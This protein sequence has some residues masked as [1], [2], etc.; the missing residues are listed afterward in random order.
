[1]ATRLAILVGSLALSGA[2]A[3]PPV[4]DV[5]LPSE[6]PGKSAPL[7]ADEEA[8]RDALTRFGVGLLRARHDQIAT[9]AKQQEAAAKKQPTAAAPQKEL[10]KLYAELGREPAAAAAGEKALAADPHDLDTAR[11]LGRLYADARRHADA[12]RVLRLAAASKELTDPVSKLVVLKDLAKAADAANDPVAATARTD[13]LALLKERRVKFLHPD[14]FTVAELERERLRQYE[15]LGVALLRKAEFAAAVAAFESARDIAA[16][17]KGAND[18]AGVVRLHWNLSG[19]RQ[20]QGDPAK[21][22]A[23]LEK[24]LL[25]RPTAFEPYERFV[26]LMKQQKRGDELPRRLSDLADANPKILA[27]QWLAAADAVTRTPTVVHET[28]RKLIEKG[29]TPDE[30]R[31]LTA[32]YRDADKPKELLDL[33]DRAYKAVRPD[34]GEEPTPDA[35]V[36]ADAVARSRLFT[37]AVRRMKPTFTDK[38]ITQASADLT[39]GIVRHTDT[40][41]LLYGLAERDGHMSAVADLLERSAMKRVKDVRV[42]G[43]TIAAHAHLR[44][45]DSIIEKSERL[46]HADAGRFYPHI[47]AQA[48]IAYAEL[49]R[50]PQALKAL[51]QQDLGNTPNIQSMRVRVLN[52]LG[53]HA[54][55]I[56][57]CD[58]GLTNDRLT[59]AEQRTLLVAKATTLNYQKKYAEAEAIWRELLDAAPDD[60]TVLNNLGYELADQN[61]KLD[62]AETLLRR[63]VEIDAWERGRQG[64]PDA[65]NAGYQDS[66]AWAL[67]RRGKLKE[68]RALLETAVSMPDASG[69][70]I[71]WD[72]LGDVAFRQGDKK[73]AAEAWRKAADLYRGSHVGREKGRLDEVKAKVKLAE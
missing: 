65:E 48:A 46:S 38:L 20:A 52:I 73:R 63:A 36:N 10:A 26:Q 39:A 31:V 19:V 17:P 9:A 47:V 45:W 2:V 16:D 7:S 71:V 14:V 25:H 13:A 40:L 18:P 56:K 53:D 50:K 54:A 29:T 21:A 28:F 57:E 5:P 12:V 70:G 33:L 4:S 11:L 8:R 24:Y 35:K 62:E 55:A 72:H 15:G 3:A 51:Q 66:L 32:A 49:G 44:E 1:M 60:V 67:F 43:L 37:Q 30:Y 58:T 27:P 68:A 59:P 41:E 34:G 64:D 6:P 42:K 22:L 61:R 23:E 69:D